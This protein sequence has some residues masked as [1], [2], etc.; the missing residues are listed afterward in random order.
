[1]YR[2]G[3]KKKERST[4]RQKMGKKVEDPDEL[5]AKGQGRK[6]RTKRQQRIAKTKRETSI[7]RRWRRR[8]RNWGR[9]SFKAR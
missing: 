8:E 2:N 4:K 3:S 7:E 1:M 9:C 5:G 6:T